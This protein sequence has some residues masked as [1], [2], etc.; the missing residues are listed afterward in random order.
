MSGLGKA[1]GVILRQ[2]VLFIDPCSLRL[3]DPPRL[4]A[5]G[6]PKS[7]PHFLI[8][9]K[10]CEPPA[11]A[12]RPQSAGRLTTPLFDTGLFTTHGEAIYTAIMLSCRTKHQAPRSLVICNS[13]H[14]L[15]DAKSRQAGEI[16]DDR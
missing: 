7:W 4:D 8:D 10:P 3:Y 12:S 16:T 15:L 9:G 13:C 6:S 1:A 14:N 2:A 11:T 5:A